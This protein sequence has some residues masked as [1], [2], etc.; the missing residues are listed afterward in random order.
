[1]HNYMLIRDIDNNIS[2]LNRCNKGCQKGMFAKNV[3]PVQN[4][5][6]QNDID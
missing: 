4:D 1:M 6:C 3:A 5:I 2:R